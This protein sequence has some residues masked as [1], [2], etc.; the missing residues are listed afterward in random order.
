MR[1]QAFF[2]W[3]KDLSVAD[4]TNLFNLFGL[5]PF[6]PPAFLAIGAWPLMMGILM[7]IQMQLNP[8]P[9]DPLQKRIFQLMPIFFTSYGKLPCWIGNLL[10]ME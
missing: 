10:D 7:F 2:C 6:S 1:H 8:P 4:P 3:I 5:L 9:P